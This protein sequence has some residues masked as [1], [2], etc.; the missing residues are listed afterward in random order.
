MP[1]FYNGRRFFLTYARC[2]E[3]K[4]SLLAF[5]EGKATIKTYVICSEKHEDGS[6]H[7]HACV[8]FC[9]VQRHAVTWLD[10]A[11]KHPNKQ[12]PRRWAA[13]CQY[14]KKDG[15]FIED[16]KAVL[17]GIIA[18]VSPYVEC[19]SYN[20]KEDW[21]DYCVAN[22]ITFQYA[23]W[24]WDQLHS[25]IP[26]LW[27]DEHAG[28]MVDR[29][30]Q[31]KFNG[32]IHKTVILLGPSGT[33]KTTW[34]KI[35]IPKPALFVTHVDDLK[36]FNKDTHVS[37]IFDDVDFNHFPRTSQ[38]HLCDFDNPR[39]IH[40]RHAVARIPAGV[41]K[42]FTCNVMPVNVGEPAIKRRVRVIRV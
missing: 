23:S 20:K 17:E 14:C 40:C 34:A 3:S 8:E 1:S 33:G 24:Y 6:P 32:D 37:I 27:D 2:A 29:L 25:T 5:L 16:D 42:I 15:D 39:S 12:D 31:L 4:E 38:I 30:K 41:F 19:A 28:V 11:G 21:F 26:T 36:L 9:D 13:C 7:L 10:F 35:S 18:G 22:K